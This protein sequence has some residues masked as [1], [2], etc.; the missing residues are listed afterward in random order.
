MDSMTT[1]IFGLGMLA[2]CYF[3]LIR[4]ENKRKK[5]LES[6][7]SQLGAGDEITT[8]GGIVGTVVTVKDDVIVIET[9]ADRVR[10]QITKWAVA[11]SGTQAQDP[12]RK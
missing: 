7:R 1:L 9:G 12:N 5:Q 8:I 2:V 10:L 11:S 3:L 4:P 6:L